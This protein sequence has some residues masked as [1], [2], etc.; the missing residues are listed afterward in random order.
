MKSWLMCRVWILPYVWDSFFWQTSG[1]WAFTETLCLVLTESDSLDAILLYPLS[2]VR[3][4]GCCSVAF[5]RA[6]CF[7]SGSSPAELSWSFSFSKSCT[8]IRVTLIF[9]DSIQSLKF[10]FS[11][12]QIPFSMLF[13]VSI[14]QQERF[15]IFS[16]C[17]QCPPFPCKW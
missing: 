15:N 3:S 1:P 11:S 6:P 12:N 17:R 14:F 9:A 8:E 13:M 16:F 10:Y 4:A 5:S 7:F 2:L